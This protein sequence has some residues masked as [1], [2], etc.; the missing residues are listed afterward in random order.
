MRRQALCPVL[1]GPFVD[2]SRTVDIS[3]CSHPEAAWS[4]AFELAA[5]VISGRVREKE[6][7]EKVVASLLDLRKSSMVRQFVTQTLALIIERCNIATVLSVVWTRLRAVLK[8]PEQY[9]PELL[10][11]AVKFQTAAGAH[12]KKCPSDVL[13]FL[14][15]EFYSES[16]LDLMLSSIYETV[17]QLHPQVHI[18][19]EAMLQYTFGSSEDPAVVATNFKAFWNKFIGAI[20]AEEEPEERLKQFRCSRVRSIIGKRVLVYIEAL[21]DE[22]VR[23][24]LLYFMHRAQCNLVVDGLWQLVKNR[25][26]PVLSVDSLIRQFQQLAEVIPAKGDDG[27]KNESADE[28][29]EMDDWQPHNKGDSLEYV[30]QSKRRRQIEK[31]KKVHKSTGRG[32]TFVFFVR[33][34]QRY[35]IHCLKLHLHTPGATEEMKQQVS[36]SSPSSAPPSLVTQPPIPSHSVMH[37]QQM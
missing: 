31:T 32:L 19:W 8:D 5:L 16:I 24:D 14:E 37:S 33:S 15:I 26:E 10:Y 1:S 12:P 27:S 9:T 28:D 17:F 6:C 11:L 36:T 35:I 22:A 3:C 20:L 23:N 21:D 4:K 13:K 34:V 29:D 18:M 30:L 2:C 7:I 25:Q